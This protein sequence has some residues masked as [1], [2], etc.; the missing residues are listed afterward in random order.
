MKFWTFTILLCT[1]VASY[2]TLANIDRNCFDGNCVTKNG[3]PLNKDCAK[4][5]AC[6]DPEFKD[7]FLDD[8]FVCL[9]ISGSEY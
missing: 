2:L 3:A 1:I 7:L 8:E 5:E 6:V 9:K 4:E